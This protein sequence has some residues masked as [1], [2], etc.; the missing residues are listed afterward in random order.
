[1]KIVSST[2]GLT[3]AQKRTK[4]IFY[5]TYLKEQSTIPIKGLISAVAEKKSSRVPRYQN[6]KIIGGFCD[7]FFKPLPWRGQ[8]GLGLRLRSALPLATEGTQ[9]VPSYEEGVGDDGGSQGIALQKKSI[10]LK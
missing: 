9:E 4:T 8:R 5:G 10:I 2:K 7:Y 3:L 6:I 1:M